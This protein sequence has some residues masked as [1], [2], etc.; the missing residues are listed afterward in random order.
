MSSF[1]LFFLRCGALSRQFLIVQ[2]TQGSNSLIEYANHASVSNV[3]EHSYGVFTL[4]MTMETVR[5]K[6][7]TG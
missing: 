7:Q 5:E 4:N 6:P 3:S 2:S 1:L